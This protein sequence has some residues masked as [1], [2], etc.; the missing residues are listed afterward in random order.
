MTG[1]LRAPIDAPFAAASIPAPA[2][3]PRRLKTDARIMIVDDETVTIKLVQKYLRTA[4]YE[5]F[6]TTDN[7]RAALSLLRTER[8]DVLLLD[9]M[10]PHVNGLEILQAIR[11]D[12]AL[13]HLPVLIL[14]AAGDE[15][16]R[17]Q[18]LDLGATDFLHKP[19]KPTELAPRVRN[20]LIVKAHHDHLAA[21]S[22]HLEEEVRQR[23]AEL[24]QSREEVL[25]VLACAAEHRDQDTGNHVLRVGRCSGILAS[26][27]GFDASYVEL[28]EQAAILHDVGK[29]GIPDSIL[30]KPG[31]LTPVEMEHMKLHCEY[32]VNILKGISNGVGTCYSSSV[33]HPATSSPIL[34]LAATI[35]AS[36]HERWDGSGYPLGLAGE[37]IPVE[38][39][40]VAVVDVL[41]ALCSRRPY[42]EPYPFEASVQILEDGRGRHFDPLV[43]DAFLSRQSQIEQTLK[44]F[45]DG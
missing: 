39:R 9:I 5:H 22:A 8:P 15:R 26:E 18:A 42:K 34:R 32:G 38:G 28:F 31:K 25:H 6:V 7:S 33:R 20:A 12:A 1:L 23:T 14:T 44:E 11:G 10:M 17:L 37:A 40:I 16:T 36:H 29:I 4:G 19:I 3:A 13:E 43:L 21:Y 30:L 35:A 45:Q 24:I 27:L 41:D 2:R